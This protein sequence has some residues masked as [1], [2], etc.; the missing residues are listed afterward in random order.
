VTLLHEFK[1]E[2]RLPSY[3]ANRIQ[4]FL[5]AA[6]TDLRLTRKS[7]TEVEVAPV[8]PYNIA[9]I[10]IQGL[11]RFR[12]TAVA[13][14]HPGGVG[15][16]Y[17][18]WAVA[19]KQKVVETPKP[20]T[21]ETDYSFDLRITAAGAEPSGE[22][23]DVFAKI[24][25][26]AW[27]GAEITALA[28]TY[29][30]VTGPM[31]QSGALSSNGDIAWTREANGAWVPQLKANSVGAA[32]LADESVDTAAIIALAVTE[33]KV[34]AEAITA[35]KLGAL[36]VTEPKLA[37]LAVTTAKLAALAVTEEKLAGEAVSTAKIK[38]LAITAALLAAEA[39]E[40]GKI[41]NLAVTAGKLG[42][43][44]VETA[45]I[46]A[47]AVTTAKIA[48]EAVET[49]QIKN[50]AV[51]AAKLA[52]ESVEEGKIKALAVTAAKLAAL[53][54][55]EAKIA[56]A[57]VSSRKWK[58]A[59]GMLDA[60][61]GLIL[62]E[63]WQDVPGCEIVLSV[64]EVPVPSKLF[65]W[66]DWVVE[67]AGGAENT[68]IALGGLKVDAEAEPLSRQARMV[69]RAFTSNNPGSDASMAYIINLASANHTI[70]MQAKRA[71]ANVLS[72]TKFGTGLI[73]MLAAQ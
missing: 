37:A 53:A 4:D 22:G 9:A 10:A 43:E 14:A 3:F 54:V 27:S 36:A 11:W 57:A 23:V 40:T 66:A 2:E 1:R 25:E 71:G 29:N 21:D 55:T 62:T 72:L 26:I 67:P 58:P 59:S 20:F 12:T 64:A 24:G 5:S 56:D 47:L 17:H 42:E 6:R 18:V 68:G 49:G 38:L 51:T 31:I 52:A 15:G 39:V 33:A 61:A 44:A 16:T 63:A 13:R 32:E 69:V 50:L 19:T 30:G 34:A 28:Q 41:K 60:S 65:V 35:G 70:K 46:K 7:A 45:K 73:W 48:N 8:G